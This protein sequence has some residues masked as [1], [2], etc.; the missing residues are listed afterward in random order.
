MKL[1]S[2]VGA[3]PN[4]MKIA[5]FCHAVARVSG[6]EHVL[7]HTGQHYDA[8]M[9]EAF[10]EELQ[11]APP[12]INLGIGSGSHAEQVG[13]CM[14]ELEK[15][16]RAERPDW[17]VVVG[18]IN[19]ACAAAQTAAKEGIKVAHIESGLRSFDRSMPEEINRLVTDRLADLLLAPDR[20]AVENL[21]REG[22]TADEIVLA[23][24]IMIDTLR[25]QEQ[26]AAALEP[27]RLLRDN[28]FDAAV[29][30]P[31]DKDWREHLALMTL[32]RPGNVDD[33]Q[34]SRR[35]VD[36]VLDE[37]ARD[38]TVVFPIH[39]RTAKM[40][41][42]NGLLAELRRNPRIVLL[43]PVGYLELLRLNQEARL[44]LTD[45]GGVQEECCVLGTPCL[46]LRDNTER[47]ITLHEHG[48]SNFLV[49]SDPEKMRQAYRICCRDFG[50]K[51]PSVPPFWDGH[52]AERMVAAILAASK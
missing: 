37:V 49:G 27:D 5:P 15:V 34:R 26:R 28:V 51:V 44:F 9:S 47:P 1:L 22:R 38:F 10:F 43:Q 30:L 7:V 3:R 8:R 17:V 13:R 16:F 32:H 20:I 11:I 50:G 52:A 6:L 19:A 31:A 18:D 4:F 46:T 24:N 36:F 33:P 35:I 41:R 14:I 29:T 42:E 12:K 23:G 25:A 48:G 45:S 39:P 2:V 40:W 21:R